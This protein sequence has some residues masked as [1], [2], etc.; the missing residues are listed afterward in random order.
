MINLFLKPT[1][2]EEENIDEI[3]KEQL[4]LEFSMSETT[5]SSNGLQI[6]EV[7]EKEIKPLVKPKFV[8]KGQKSRNN[9]F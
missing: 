8:K 7:K 3:Y 4:D 1:K 2:K 6:T 9:L 5:Y